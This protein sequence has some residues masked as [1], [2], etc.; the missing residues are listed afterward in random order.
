MEYSRF[1]N[2]EEGKIIDDSIDDVA[3]IESKTIS[4][5]LHYYG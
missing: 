3:H 2:K 5:V 1:L 4:R